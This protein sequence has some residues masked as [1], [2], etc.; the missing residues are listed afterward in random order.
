MD[1]VVECENERAI[2]IGYMEKDELTVKKNEMLKRI[3]IKLKPYGFRKYGDTFY[4]IVSEDI[5]QVINFQRGQ[6]YRNESALMWVN[7]GIRIPECVMREFFLSAPLKKYYHEYECNIRSRLGSIDGKEEKCFNLNSDI[8][9]IEKEIIS[10]IEQKVLPVFEVLS[11]REAILAR[12]R[13]FKNFD[14]MNNHLILLEESMIYGHLGN[15]NKA[16]ELF[17]Q[18][19][20]T[21]VDKYNDRVKNGKKHYLKKGERIVYCGQDIT[22]EEDG[23]VTIYGAS[24]GHIDYLDELAEKLGLTR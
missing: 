7:L 11:S 6:S 1:G 12:R 8:N 2:N 4:R 23:Y 24:H 9:T 21:A 3:H 13:E 5:S 16:K 22:A 14:V 17:R 20:N 18:Y 19:Y 10:D 15:M